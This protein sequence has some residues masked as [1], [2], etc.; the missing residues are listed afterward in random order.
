[1]LFQLMMAKSMWEFSPPCSTR[2]SHSSSP[3]I[4]FRT[5]LRTSCESGKYFQG[6]SWMWLN[7]KINDKHWKNMLKNVWHRSFF[8][9][10][11]T[12]Q[13]GAQDLTWSL[14]DHYHF[15]ILKIYV[16]LHVESN[17]YCLPL[18]T[19]LRIIYFLFRNTI[20]VI[21]SVGVSF[22]SPKDSTIT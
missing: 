3:A 11:W 14:I 9:F 1:M 18:L 4:F 13:K 10:W 8:Y 5:P 7:R 22:S 6:L 19:Q 20:Q 17:I 21:Q 2:P 12:W 15:I 16:W